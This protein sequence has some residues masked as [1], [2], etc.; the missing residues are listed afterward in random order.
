MVVSHHVVAGNWP[1]NLWKSSQC[2]QP[3]SHLS[4]PKKGLISSYISTLYSIIKARAGKNWWQRPWRRSCS[5]WLSHPTFLANPG[6]PA[7]GWYCLV[8]WALPHWPSSKKMHYRLVQVYLVR[9][10]LSWDS[11]FQ[12]DSILCQDDIKLTRTLPENLN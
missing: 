7:Q 11:L 3:L 5:S 9:F 6:L 2:S 12:N 8:N 4:S 10:F 1:Q